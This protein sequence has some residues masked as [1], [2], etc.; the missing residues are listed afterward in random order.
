M[1]QTST[2]QPRPASR[3]PST[4][5]SRPALIGLAVLLIVGGA[6]ASAWL[7]IQSGNRAYFVQVDQEIAQGARSP[8]TTS[9]GSASRRAS[10][11]ASRRPTSDTVVG[12]S[13]TARLLPAP[14]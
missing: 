11:A 2:K 4:R 14:S 8:R 10:R 12:K 3:L 7:A 5:E 13:A 1:V 9:A 6:L